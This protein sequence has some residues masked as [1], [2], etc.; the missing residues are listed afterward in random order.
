MWPADC[1]TLKA[2]LIAQLLYLPTIN[3]YVRAKQASVLR[4][5]LFTARYLAIYTEKPAYFHMR[6]RIR[7]IC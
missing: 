5:L 1:V 4:V 7:Q 2:V 6:L 3:N